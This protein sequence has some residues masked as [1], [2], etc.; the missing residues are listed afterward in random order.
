M[1]LFF[2]FLL[3]LAALGVA[4]GGSF[5]IDRLYGRNLSILTFPDAIASRSRWRKPLLFI[6]FLGYGLRLL[7]LASGL[8]LVLM[9]VFTAF[10]LWMTATDF[11]QYCLFDSMMLPFA[12]AALVML[13]TYPDMLVSHLLA[14]LA[15]GLVFLVLGILSRGALG[16]GDI[17]LL[18]ALG[19]WMGPQSLVFTAAAGT[20]LGGLAALVLLLTGQKKRKSSFAYGPYFMLTALVLMLVRGL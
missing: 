11:E 19:L 18:A 17:K 3:L 9:L 1:T 20:V 16:G 6:G 2:V 15:G 5:W 13:A 10:L 4:W 14:G 12:L 8:P 7:Q